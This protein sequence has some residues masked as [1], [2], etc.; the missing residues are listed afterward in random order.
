MELTTKLITIGFLLAYFTG[1]ASAD[2]YKSEVNSFLELEKLVNDI[3]MSTSTLIVMD[4]DDTLTMMPCDKTKSDKFCQ[5]LGGPAWYAWQDDLLKNYLEHNEDS[6]YR[7]ADSEK[8]LLDIAALLLA[9]NNMPYTDENIPDVLTKL[10]KK[11]VRLMVETARGN[12]NVASTVNQF[13]NR[14]TSDG[15]FMSLIQDNS[16]LFGTRNTPSL[17]SPFLACNIPG[18]RAIS[19]QQGVMYVSGQNK[20][21]MLKCILTQYE[22]NTVASGNGYSISDIV[23]IDDTLENVVDVYETFKND[24]QYKTHALHYKALQKHKADLTKGSKKEIYQ[25]NAHSRWINIKE[26]MESNLLQ[27]NL[28]K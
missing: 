15:D 2:A 11:G 12:S 16:L 5:Y 25:K 3:N 10:S 24:K 9:M 8:Q 28:G 4:D 13:E 27:P 6:E 19:Y 17:A 22:N 18:S 1:N 7:V 14:P 26:T 20:G 21:V 23:F